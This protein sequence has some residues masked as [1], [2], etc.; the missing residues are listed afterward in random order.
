MQ[1]L[2]STRQIK[3]TLW[4]I[5]AILVLSIVL[6]LGSNAVRKQHLPIIGD[7]SNEGRLITESGD[8]LAIPFSEAVRHFK[9]KTAIFIDARG[10]DLFEQGHI[11]GALNLPWH[12]VDNYFVNLENDIQ[13]TDKV[14]TYCDGET[15]NLSHDLALFLMEMGFQDVNVL[16]NGWTIWL[17]NNQPV[18]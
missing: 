12:D 3:R 7:W 2:Y 13:P 18:D 17:D 11:Q 1:F 10:A 14:I 8:T 15:C 5:P 4:Q 16:V 9:R 6:G